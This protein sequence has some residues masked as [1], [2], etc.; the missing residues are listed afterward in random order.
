MSKPKVS[1][2]VPI[3]GVEKYIERCARSLFEQTLESIEYIFVDDCTKDKSV[4]IL[5]RV[6]N[7]YPNRKKQVL[8][9]KMPQ[10]VGQC[11]VR[12][13]AIQHATGEF[14]IHCDS[15]DW[16]DTTMYEKM[17]SKAISEEA[18]MVICDYYRTDGIINN[19]RKMTDSYK[20]MP[21]GPL[22]NKLV[23]RS[24]Y[25]DKEI[26]YP[27]ANKAEDGTLI[28]QFYYYSKKI[29]NL[30][31]PLYFYYINTDSICGNI[32]ETS[33]VSKLHQEIVNLDVRIAFLKKQN[34]V[35]KYAKD[36][37]LWKFYARENLSPL[38][39]QIKY[40]K[41]YESVF[42]YLD[43]KILLRLDL[44]LGLKKTILMRFLQKISSYFK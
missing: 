25:A 2:L 34:I 44:P 30:H 42:P 14:V 38:L 39:D 41:L 7:E 37:Y 24:V 26:M 18:D 19:Y 22:W 4:E 9:H 10:N 21:Q 17:Y 28:T 13:W 11:G 29:V 3:Y 23:R 32:S 33:C 12:K 16:V 1:V 43:I 35:N 15:D 5:S 36:V 27:L 40:Q 20:F 31:E 6:L 8:I